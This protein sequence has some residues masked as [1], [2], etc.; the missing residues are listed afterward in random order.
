MNQDEWIL[1]GAGLP[2]SLQVDYSCVFERYHMPLFF[3]FLKKLVLLCI[4][5]NMVLVSGN[6]MG[7][8]SVQTLPACTHP[9]V[10]VGTE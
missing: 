7:C 5:I 10:Q 2:P 3:E 9:T 6:F 4:R 1:D 8:N